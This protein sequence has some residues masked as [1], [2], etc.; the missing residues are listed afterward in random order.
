MDMTKHP[1]AFNMVYQSFLILLFLSY[2]LPLSIFSTTLSSLPFFSGVESPGGL[3][4]GCVSA[5][6]P[7]ATG[8]GEHLLP[9]KGSQGTLNHIDFL[10]SFFPFA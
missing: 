8:T 4:G 5:I 2:Y 10:R 9:E 7:L 6:L 3:D 1:Y